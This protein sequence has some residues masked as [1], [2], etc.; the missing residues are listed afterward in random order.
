MCCL[1]SVGLGSG[2]VGIE[3]IFLANSITKARPTQVARLNA[4][5]FQTT[6]R[7]SLLLF[8]W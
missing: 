3:F 7:P 2:A 4:V 6:S 1:I 8:M 5:C